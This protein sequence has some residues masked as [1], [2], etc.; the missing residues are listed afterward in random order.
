MNK[1]LFSLVAT[2]LLL[3][4][5]CKKDDEDTGFKAVFS[6]VADGFVVNFTNFSREA[7]EYEWDFGDGAEGSTR[8]NPSHIF[9]SK[10]D[11]LVTLTAKNGEQVDVFKDTVFIVG[12]NIK[13]D[14]DFTDWTYVDY[15]LINTE[16]GGGTLRA[17]KTFASTGHIN[18][19][20]EGTEDMNLELF[21]MYIDSDNNLSTGYNTWMYPLGSAAEY[22]FEGYPAA[23]T[24][25][26]HSGEQS[27][28]NWISVYSFAEVMQFSSIKTS[29]DIKIVEFSVAKNRLGALSQAI[30]MCFM[31][32][33]AGWNIIGSI[34]VS[35]TVE[36]K[37]L[38]VD[39]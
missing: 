21:D 16:D 35:G 26:K 36:S 27:A 9:T 30:N 24:V 3:S 4:T 19:Y 8:K 12:P 15:A 29:G 18:F 5:S 34:P 13:I 37:F 22:L 17:I 23:G 33:D 1:I 32:M 38:K 39:L 6:Y 11:Y 20:L 14:G 7:N 2:F 10:G 28:W 31:E 25:Y